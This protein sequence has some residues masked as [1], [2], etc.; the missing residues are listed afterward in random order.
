MRLYAV[1]SSLHHSLNTQYGVMAVPSILVFHNSRPLYK[2]NYT[3][4]S[5][6]GFTQFVRQTFNHRAEPCIKLRALEIITFKRF[7]RIV[8]LD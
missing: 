5:L 8:S 4:Y 1:D 3:E 2:Y 6:A 7:A